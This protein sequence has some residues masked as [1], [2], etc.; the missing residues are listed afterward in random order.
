[1]MLPRYDENHKLVGFLK[2]KTISLVNENQMAGTGVI[3]EFFD[4][5]Q[6]SGGRI[7]MQ[8]VIF[9]KI[10]GMLS[11]REPV[12]IKSDKLTASG[13]GIYYSFEESKGFLIGPATTTIIA[14]SQTAMNSNSSKLRATA[15]SLAVATQAI[16][17]APPE[18]TAQIDASNKEARA[19]LTK[20]LD[21]SVA[22]LNAAKSFLKQ[23]DASVT[24]SAPIPAPDKPLEVKTSDTETVIHCEGGMY[25]DAEEG[26]LVYLKNVTVKD[27]RFNLSGANEVKVFFGK[28]PPKGKSKTVDEKSEEPKLGGKIGA[29]FGDVEKIIATGAVLLEQV[30]REA[31]REPIKASGAIFTYRLKE[32][33]VTISGGF[34]WVVQGATYLRAKQANLTLRLS[35]KS[36]NI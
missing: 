33:Q 29:N 36:W 11:A 9:D 10:N 21:D 17:A 12:D 14:P 7:S 6:T 3:V 25:F 2:S 28:K 4:E 8:K 18:A 22:A 5:D 13:S 35:P 19:D 31:N 24:T 23:A 32:D 15:L 20:D 26:V 27:P 34:P 1:M 30:A 16:N